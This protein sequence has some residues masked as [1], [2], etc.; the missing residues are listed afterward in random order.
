[1]KILISGYYGFD[2]AGDEAILYS[3]LKSFNFDA[4]IEVLSNDPIKTQNEFNVSSKNRWKI[5]EITKAMKNCD[6]FVSGGG[7][8]LQDT[9]SNKNVMYYLFL[10]LVAKHYRKKIVFYSQ[11]IGPIRKW[12]NKMLMKWLVNKVDKIFVRDVFSK[13]K[14]I[15]FGVKSEKIEASIDPVM[16]I[17]ITEDIVKKGKNILMD[18]T[19]LNV[20]ETKFVG[21]YVR[22]WK[23]KDNFEDEVKKVCE[24]FIEKKYTPI[25]IPM[26]NPQDIEI[27]KNIKEMINGNAILISKKYTAEEVM[28]LTANMD[29]V[30]GM[31]L[32]AI[33]MAAAASVPYIGISYDPKVD[34]FVSE[35]Q[36]SRTFEAYGLDS[37]E[38]TCFLEDYLENLED[39]KIKINENRIKLAKRAK[40]PIEYLKQLSQSI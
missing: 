22:D 35:M 13:D 12:Y 38:I 15:E 10:V 8:L 6:I 21:I 28:A 34:Y 27:S 32:H 26:Q 30:I 24:F 29:F 33:I 25:F 2:N 19:N 16:G 39:E 40:L 4:D 36:V 20:N 1:M 17:D 37:K 14:L 7:S 31:R 9:T 18:E 5:R 3:M 11:G 23:L